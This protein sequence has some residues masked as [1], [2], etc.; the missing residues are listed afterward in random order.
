M[1]YLDHHA[2]APM[3]ETVW[4]AMQQ[5]AATAWANPSSTHAAGRASKQLLENARE[6]VAGAIGASAADVVLTAGGTEACNLGVRGLA[7][8]RSRLVS[9]A[10]EHPAV[11]QSVRR[12][13]REGRQLVFLDVRSGKPP[14]PDEL[15]YEFW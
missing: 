6:A 2:A 15:S 8:G 3:P 13:G 1:I 7:E 10:V 12:L 4:R 5:A 14:E 11:A 9:T